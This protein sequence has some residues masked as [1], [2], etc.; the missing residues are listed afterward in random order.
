MGAVTVT[1]RKSGQIIEQVERPLRS[2]AG[3]LA[4]VWRKQLWRLTDGEVDLDAGPLDISP[5]DAGFSRAVAPPSYVVSP[6]TVAPRAPLSPL[7]ELPPLADLPP[8]PDDQAERDAILV[9]DAGTRMLVEAGPGT[10][11]T[12][13]AALRLSALDCQFLGHLTDGHSDIPPL[14]LN[15]QCRTQPDQIRIFHVGQLIQKNHALTPSSARPSPK[16]ALRLPPDRPGDRPHL[17]YDVPA[18]MRRQK[19]AGRPMP[20]RWGI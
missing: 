7:P 20:H 16:P 2:A 15:I 10:G 3:G 8:P 4:I 13:I 11:K 6:A 19:S 9:A 14:H 12:Q 1:I 5:A 17:S 18:E